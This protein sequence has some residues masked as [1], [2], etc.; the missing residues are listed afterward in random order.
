VAGTVSS[1]AYA[2]NRARKLLGT[3]RITY[4]LTFKAEV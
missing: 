2:G 3:D 4:S 1:I